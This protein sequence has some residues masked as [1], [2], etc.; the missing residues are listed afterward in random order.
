MA[1]GWLIDTGSNPS[2]IN[3][4]SGKFWNIPS[5][6][7]VTGIGKSWFNWGWLVVFASFYCVSIVGGVGY[8]TGVLMEILKEDLSGNIAS[9]S[10]AGSVQVTNIGGDRV[11]SVK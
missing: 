1:S 8:I 6:T 5:T 7:L 4:H 9:I 2:L 11:K 3:C 10:L